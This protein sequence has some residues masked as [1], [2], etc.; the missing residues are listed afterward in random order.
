MLLVDVREDNERGGVVQER[1]LPFVGFEDEVILAPEAEVGVAEFLEPGSHN[2]RRIE[3]TPHQSEREQGGGRALAVGAGDGER[4]V[5]AGQ[6]ADSLRIGIDR[7][8]PLPGL[9]KLGISGRNGIIV[10]N[11]AY[12]G[13]Q[14]GLFMPYFDFYAVFLEILGNFTLRYIRAKNSP[15]LGLEP[16]SE[17]THTDTPDT[18]EIDA[19][20]VDVVEHKLGSREQGLGYKNYLPDYLKNTPEGAKIPVLPPLDICFMIFSE[21]KK[22]KRGEEKMADFTVYFVETTNSDDGIEMSSVQKKEIPAD[23]M[24]DAILTIGEILTSKGEKV[25]YVLRIENKDCIEDFF[26]RLPD[27]I[28]EVYKQFFHPEPEEAKSEASQP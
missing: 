27:Q 14:I 21:D 5:S 13:L 7:E 23:D 1:R 22:I 25:F 28:K 24:K 9:Q 16:L 19:F 10:D 12:L 4:L 2:D 26:H 3:S 18:D 8:P 6:F 17:G 11:Q 20:F 15:I